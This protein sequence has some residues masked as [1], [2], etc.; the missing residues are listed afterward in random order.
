MLYE[1]GPSDRGWRGGSRGWLRGCNNG[2]HDP[3]TRT[4][5]P[6]RGFL[7]RMAALTAALEQFSDVFN[8]MIHPARLDD[9]ET[10]QIDQYGSFGLVARIDIMSLGC[11]AAKG[12]HPA[13][14]AV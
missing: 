1:V 10:A 8:S 2:K 6:L 4:S 9:T 7:P 13:V 5:S 12:A 14:W 11:I 3:G